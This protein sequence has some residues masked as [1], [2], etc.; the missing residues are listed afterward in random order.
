MKSITILFFALF[1]FFPSE[2]LTA[3]LNW[4]TISE[5][6]KHIVSAKIAW[7]FGLAYEL[8]YNYQLKS[9]IPV[10]LQASYSF[11][12]GSNLFDD[13]KT[14]LGAQA[15]LLQYKEFHFSLGIYGLY[16][17][18]ETP[19]ALMHNFGGEINGA[20]G[21]Y[22]P[23]WFV[24]AEAGFDKAIVTYFKHSNT[25]KAFIYSDVTDGWYKPTAGGHFNFGLQAGYSF[26]RNDIVF[27]FGKV[28]QQDFK[29]TPLIPYYFRLGYQRK[30]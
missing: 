4:G 1:F 24:A 29:G 21:Y 23:K 12:S 5:E 14:K 26:K 3:Q 27:R 16:R 22:K 20:I 8:G 30:F 18:F 7:D 28:I 15:K 13:F 17:R 2:Y 9:P 11:P 10:F 6:D 19:L 25:Y